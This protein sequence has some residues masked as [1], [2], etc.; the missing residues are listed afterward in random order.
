MS[1]KTKTVRILPDRWGLFSIVTLAGDVLMTGMD[2][3]A[4]YQWAARRGY[5]VV[6]GSSH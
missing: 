6:V 2:A 5:D 1:T 4:A 3:G